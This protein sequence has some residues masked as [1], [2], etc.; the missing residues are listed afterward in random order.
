MLAHQLK[1]APYVAPVG[2]TTVSW[3]A[4]AT[5]GDSSSVTIPSASQA[6]DLA[7]LFQ[8]SSKIFGTV[9]Y[10]NPSGWTQDYD[11]GSSNIRFGINHKILASGDPGSSIT[12]MNDTFDSKVLF[13]FRLSSGAITGVT[14]VSP[15]G[16]K[17]SGNPSARVMASAT[18]PYIAASGASAVSTPAVWSTRSPTQDGE[19]IPP[20][21]SEYMAA[22]YWVRNAG[23]EESITVDMNDLGSMNILT[24]VVFEVS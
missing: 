10:V 17:T 18:A 13:V 2:G 12:G 14:V 3:V 19:G 23:E 20:T 16:Q 24:S 8:Q 6:G 11:S 5:S 1:R 22:C 21:G 15:G 9:S 7:V 4:T